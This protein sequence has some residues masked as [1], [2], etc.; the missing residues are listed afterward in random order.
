MTLQKTV[1]DRGEGFARQFLRRRGYA[2]LETNHANLYGEIDIIAE[3]DGLL[4]FVEV[5]T[6]R[7][8][9]TEAALAGITPAKRERLIN[10]IHLYLHQR[11]M[12]EDVAWRLDVIAVALA[13]RRPPQIDHVE[14]AFDW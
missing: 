14:D 6:R 1:G 3:R 7:D 8:A 9:S 4:V 5:K 10:A 11:C 2:I 12:G 13:P